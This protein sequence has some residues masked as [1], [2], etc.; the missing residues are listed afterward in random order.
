MIT[1]KGTALLALL[2]LLATGCAKEEVLPPGTLQPV[3]KSAPVITNGNDSIAPGDNGK[4]IV[5]I[6]D[7][8]DDLGDNERSRQAKH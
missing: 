6:T 5:P 1:L 8:G 3:L 7:D 4:G 2:L